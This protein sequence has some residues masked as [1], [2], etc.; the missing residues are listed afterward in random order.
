MKKRNRN[1]INVYV[2]MDGVIADFFAEENAVE[3][4]EN[5]HHFFRILRPKN[6]WAFEQL[7]ANESVNVFVLSASP[8]RR[9][10][11]D[12]KAWLN[13]YFPQ[14]KR[15]NIIIMRNGKKKVDYMKTETGVLLDDY[16]KNCREWLEKKG[17]KSI[18]VEKDLATY[19]QEFLVLPILDY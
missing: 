7:L 6:K 4:F 13:F 19:F 11:K 14:I 15:R 5:E 8:N 3:R 12:K 10:D 1:K 17:N 16:G 9:C 18:K 2:D